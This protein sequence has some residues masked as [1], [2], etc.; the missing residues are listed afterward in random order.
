MKV[1][2]R[3]QN[4]KRLVI[5]NAIFDYSIFEIIARNC[6]NLEV[7]NISYCGNLLPNGEMDMDIQNELIHLRH[8]TLTGLKNFTKTNILISFIKACKALV[9]LEIEGTSRQF[10]T[11]SYICMYNFSL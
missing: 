3:Q 1:L 9:S 11:H 7:L 2:E 8:M 4:L 6:K 5:N 10:V